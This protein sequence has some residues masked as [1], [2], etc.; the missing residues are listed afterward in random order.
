MSLRGLR[1]GVI[2]GSIAG[3]A[4]AVLLSRS[5]QDVTVFERS[6]G[7]V[8]R[9]G[10][11]GL[12]FSG[13][14]KLV[15]LDL[16]DRDMPQV[17]APKRIWRVKDGEQRL[18][19]LLKRQ[20]MSVAAAHW[21]LLYNQLLARM[22]PRDYRIGVP[23]ER[24]ERRSAGPSVR[25][26]DGAQH[27]FDIV[28]GA[29]GYRSQTRQQLFP[30]VMQSYAGYCAWRGIIDESDLPDATPVDQAMH[31]I[32]TRNGHAPFYVV[33]GRGGETARGARRLNW[34]WY[35]AGV[36][37]E[38]LGLVRSADG[39]AHV[40]AVPPGGMTKRQRN[41]LR[42]IAEKQLPPWHRDV[43]RTTPKPYIQPLYDLPLKHYVEG[44]VC[45]LGDA[46]AIARP[47]T[48][49]GTLKALEDAIAL[50]RAVEKETSIEAAL[51]RYD[52]ERGS[53]GRQ[54][55]RLGQEL[56]REQVV[57]PPRW[58]E[59]DEARFDEW[60]E[61]GAT[62]IAWYAQPSRPEEQEPVKP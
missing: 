17:R 57:D 20:Q 53:V 19:R 11:I 52:S 49:S 13:I 4:V 24:V 6:S 47:H 9:G 5:S 25:T 55:V 45:L 41:Y 15:A 32:G 34:L 23:V 10:G 48:G 37:D 27:S 16:I 30:G 46:A 1:I 31:I 54:L 39:R 59:L 18:G 28:V 56:G 60:F 33:P 43:I 8:E 21:G 61:R 12:E 38:V 14:R 42:E 35:D 36:P 22:D 40:D 62:S 3:T 7:L 50:A 44:R 51:A 29:D 26:A 58:A 2:G